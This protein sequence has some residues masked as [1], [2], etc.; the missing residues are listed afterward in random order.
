MVMNSYCLRVYMPL[1]NPR[2]RESLYIAQGRH[3]ELK[4]VEG[5]EDGVKGV[6][7]IILVILNTRPLNYIVGVVPSGL[8]WGKRKLG[9]T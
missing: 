2:E 5:K 9:V 7:E 4:G 8:Y 6:S 3:T 1:L